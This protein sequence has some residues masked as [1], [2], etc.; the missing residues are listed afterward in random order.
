M[1]APLAKFAVALLALTTLAHIARAGPAQ[2]QMPGTEALSYGPVEILS[3]QVQPYLGG[4]LVSGWVERRFGYNY[5]EDF[6]THIHV[7]ILDRVGQP[8]EQIA[9]N[10][11]PRPIPLAYHGS[12]HH[13]MFAV[14]LRTFPRAAFRIRVIC[15]GGHL[16]A[17]EL[18]RHFS[19]TT[20]PALARH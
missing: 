16:M 17:A 5:P 19:R 7:L 14:R 20:T 6:S 9:S 2:R 1:F 4:L 10:Y 11:L 18:A 12:Q 3:V 15:H 13:A 8:L